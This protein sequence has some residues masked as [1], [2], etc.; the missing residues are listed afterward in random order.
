[1]LLGGGI[2]ALPTQG[3]VGRELGNEH[4]NLSVLLPPLPSPA[5][6]TQRPNPTL[7]RG[8]RIVLVQPT[9]VS[10]RSTEQ[11]GRGKA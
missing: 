5:E 11:N 7:I 9:K 1:M 8:H 10:P 6:T 3:L 4:P 2:E